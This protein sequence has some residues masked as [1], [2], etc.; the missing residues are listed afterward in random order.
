MIHMR[1]SCCKLNS[2]DLPIYLSKS[3]GWGCCRGPLQV[4]VGCHFPFIRASA[5]LCQRSHHK[6]TASL[7]K[8]SQTSQDGP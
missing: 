5:H 1:V 7:A 2:L 8:G 3:E 6:S 4:T